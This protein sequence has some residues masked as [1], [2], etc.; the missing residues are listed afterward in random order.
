MT[1]QIICKMQV[2]CGS[3][4]QGDVIFVNLYCYLCAV[5]QKNVFFASELCLI[6]TFYFEQEVVV[7][8]ARI[9]PNTKVESAEDLNMRIQVNYVN[10]RV[11]IYK[12]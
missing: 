5:Q 7:V 4:H 10:F 3:Y 8:P 6:S 11:R 9:Y 12:H 1:V 2:I